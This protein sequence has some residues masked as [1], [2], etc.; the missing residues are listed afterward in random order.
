MIIRFLPIL[1]L[2]VTAA[3][4][5]WAQDRAKQ[6]T[7]ADHYTRWFK[8]DVLYI[9]TEEEVE[10]FGKLTTDVERDQFIEQF[11]RRR[12]T[13]PMTGVNEFK[14]EHYRRIQY[15]NERFAAGI[16]GWRTDRGRV[17][18][19]HGPPDRRE[20]H[21]LGGRYDRKDYEGGG[22][23]SVFPFERW[24]YRHIE[25]LGSDVELEFVDSSGSNL[26]ELT[27]DA[28]EKDEFLRVDGMGLTFDEMYHPDLGGQK[29]WERVVGLRHGGD[30]NRSGIYF[31]RAK[32][33]PFQKA[34]LMA[35]LS[36]APKIRFTDLRN[37]VTT[38]VSYNGLPFQLVTHSFR[39]S[40]RDFLVHLTLGVDNE[41]L[42]FEE[43]QGLRRSR[44]QVYG[45][46][47]TLSNKVTFAFDDDVIADY[48]AG[49]SP[50]LKQPSTYQRKLILPPGRYKVDLVVKDSVSGRMG[51]KSVGLH[52]PAPP[53]GDLSA[54]SVILAST[55]RPSDGDLTNP[56]IVGPF[57]IKPQI[58]QV[59]EPGKSFGFYFE[60]YNFQVDQSTQRPQ[61]QVG[62]ALV[63]K[64]GDPSDF[65]NIT[66]A[67]SFT[68]DRVYF[69]RMIQLGDKSPGE[70]ELVLALSDILSQKSLTTRVPFKLR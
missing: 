50:S 12:D 56:N 10:V 29:S 37:V 39:L 30:A 55:I 38:R 25:G 34:E 21:P 63:P 51:T 59:F 64:G 66:G 36:A 5:I 13:D 41:H 33:D 4:N 57:K 14:E 3:L 2:F 15:A 53:E 27:M 26:Y 32:D 43:N 49:Q 40:Q 68:T 47:E 69:A 11:W 46:V 7:L 31:D 8:E 48:A 44:L 22:V 17:Y 67:A 70:Y 42:S 52:L 16:P 62:Y 58:D 23:T 65:R 9:I 61:L 6:E 24:E 20:R 1:I 19:M 35:K 45:Q 54:S 18:I 60:V 28:Q